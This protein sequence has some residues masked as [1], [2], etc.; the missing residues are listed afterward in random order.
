M[1]VDAYDDGRGKVEV[2]ARVNVRDKK[3]VVITEIPYGTT[4][5]GIIASI[6]AAAQKGRVKISSINDYTTENVEIELT[7]ARGVSR[8]GGRSLSSTPTP[9]APCPSRPT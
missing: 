5:E 1:D 9:I 4:T 7:L 2:R 6:E 3:H 8:Q